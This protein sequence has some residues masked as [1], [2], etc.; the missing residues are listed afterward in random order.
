MADPK[1]SRE[2][3][4]SLAVL[5]AGMCDEN[6]ESVNDQA[7]EELQKLVA[8]L[9][10]SS[11]DRDG[12][13]SGEFILSL[14]I[15]VLKGHADVVSE[16]IVKRPKAKGRELSLWVTKGGNLSTEA[17]QQQRLPLEKLTGGRE[18]NGESEGGEFRKAKEV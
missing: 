15:T 5:L 13:V 4:R 12:K 14:K 17:P 1:V 9:R 3:P 7:S 2:G 11:L 16:I 8:D 6:A 10:Q 18:P